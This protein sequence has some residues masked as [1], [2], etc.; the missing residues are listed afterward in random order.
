VAEYFFA[1]HSRIDLRASDS[2]E[3]KS[4]AVDVSIVPADIIPTRN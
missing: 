4:T 1:I 3:F 2:I